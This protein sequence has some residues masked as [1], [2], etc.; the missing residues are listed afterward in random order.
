[1]EGYSGK[2]ISSQIGTRWRNLSVVEKEKYR[3]LANLKKSFL[4]N[5]NSEP[6]ILSRAWSLTQFEQE[7]P[8]INKRRKSF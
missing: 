8:R 4:K 5:I 2:N 3:K 1:M 7:V 6:N